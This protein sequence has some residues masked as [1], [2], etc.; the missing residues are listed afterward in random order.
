MKRD[1]YSWFTTVEPKHVLKWHAVKMNGL[2]ARCG[3][4]APRNRN[5][6]SEPNEMG[7]VCEVCV[8]GLPRPSSMEMP[9]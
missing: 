4:V 3:A 8:G 7:V 6:L 5:G 9:S 2:S 1:G